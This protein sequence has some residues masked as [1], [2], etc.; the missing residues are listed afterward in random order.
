MTVAFTKASAS[1]AIMSTALLARIRDECAQPVELSFRQ[2]RRGEI[3]ERGDRLLRRS[4]K[5]RVQQL[6]Q[7]RLPRPFPRDRRDKHVA[8]AVF[9][10][11]EVPL[12]FEHP[13]QRPYRRVAGRV[14]QA[15][16]HFGRGSATRS[17]DDVHDLA[18]APAQ[19]GV[20]FFRH[21]LSPDGWAEWKVLYAKKPA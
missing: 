7:R 17:V 8:R 20:R 14:G 18:L 6:A 13:Q 12:V 16:H 5:K 3:E 11:A 10:V 1:I 4:V 21:R 19:L 2:S 15:R 9:F